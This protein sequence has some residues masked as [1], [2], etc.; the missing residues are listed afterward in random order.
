MEK[1]RCEVPALHFKSKWG[2][3]LLVITISN[4]SRSGLWAHNMSWA[5]GQHGWWVQAPS[6]GESLWDLICGEKPHRGLPLSPSFQMAW[7]CSQLLSS[8]QDKLTPTVV[9]T[10]RFYL[11]AE[12]QT[13]LITMQSSVD[14]WAVSGPGCWD[15]QPDADLLTSVP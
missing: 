14:H 6:H 9:L 4:H 1:L 8:V 7:W 10:S 15:H 2:Q 3:S 11:A 12:V 5:H 13:S